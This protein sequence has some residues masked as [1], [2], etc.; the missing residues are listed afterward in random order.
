MEPQTLPP[1][2]ELRFVTRF[3]GYSEGRTVGER[4]SAVQKPGRHNLS[5]VIKIK[6]TR[7]KLCQYRGL[8]ICCG[9]NTSSLRSSAPKPI[10]MRKT[11]DKPS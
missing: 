4:Y 8:L 2:C 5:G 7:G 1:E 9:E 10:A 6:G 11:S 3:R